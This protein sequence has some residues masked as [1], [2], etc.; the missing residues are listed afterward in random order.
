MTW[1]LFAIAAVLLAIE[2]IAYA[3]I[4][5]HPERFR[6]W[7]GR[8]SAG[9]LSGPVVAVRN[10]FLV[11]KV[12][13]VA[14]FGGWIYLHGDGGLRPREA[15]LLPLAGGLALILVGQALNVGVFLRLGTTGVF[16]GSR[17][18]YDVPRC[19]RFPF[20]AVAHPQYVGA[21]LSI[22]GVFFVTR[23]PDPDWYLL[24]ALETAYYG[25]GARLEH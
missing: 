16:Y 15:G 10:L 11:C 12:I 6:S 24:P 18:G 4:W 25:L 3:L 8:S 9:R 21:V 5:R 17:F 23:F 1:R 22:W 20:S 19:R 7:L 13:Q 14:V 2:R